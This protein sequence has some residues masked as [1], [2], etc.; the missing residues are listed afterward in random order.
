[1]VNNELQ[2]P[3]LSPFGCRHQRAGSPAKRT[4]TIINAS[5]MRGFPYIAFEGPIAA[6]KTTLA[7]L[8]AAEISAELLLEEFQTNEFLADFYNERARWSLPMQLWFLSERVPVL[9][10]LR[11]PIQRATVADYTSRKDAFFARMLLQGRE[12]RL[13][14]RIAAMIT[15]DIVQPDVVVHLDATDDVLLERILRRGRPYEETVDRSY[16]Q[17]LRCAYEQD[18]SC[19][20][21]LNVLRWDT[22]TL[23]L[24]SEGQ[25][26]TFYESVLNAASAQN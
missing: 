9:R 23:D 20:P 3:C 26:R 7:T 15:T 5:R 10:S 13:F 16:L 19:T 14:N 21:E 1:M 4:A 11:I 22:T 2:P 8:F 24:N 25:M 6:G 12:L 18:L 17:A